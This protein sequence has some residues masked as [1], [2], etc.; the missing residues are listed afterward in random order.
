FKYKA[1][2]KKALRFFLTAKNAK[3]YAKFAKIFFPNEIFSQRRKVAKF[4][5]YFATLRLCE[6]K[7]SSK[8]FANIA[9]L[10]NQP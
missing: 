4:F 10:K 5:I 3:F 6:I 2:R 8:S 7:I 9:I 1:V